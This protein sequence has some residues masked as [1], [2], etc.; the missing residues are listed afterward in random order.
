[1]LP[2]ELLAIHRYIPSWSCWMLLNL[3][4]IVSIP[5]D[6]PVAGPQ[7]FVVLS[8]FSQVNVIVTFSTLLVA[9]HDSEVL[10]ISLIITELG[11]CVIV[12]G[13]GIKRNYNDY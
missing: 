2:A 7:V 3:I 13:T 12:G 9:S 10:P 8:N 4:I 5:D 6:V 1:M 11:S